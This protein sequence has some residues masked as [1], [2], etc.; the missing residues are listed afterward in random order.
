[1]LLLFVARR[2]WGMTIPWNPSGLPDLWEI[3]KVTGNLTI[4]RGAFQI[5]FTMHH[6]V[7]KE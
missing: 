3:S 1:M 6:E 7:V 4:E 5:S 2:D